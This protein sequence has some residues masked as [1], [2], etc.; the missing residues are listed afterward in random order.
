MAPSVSGWSCAT[1]VA[2]L[3]L[4][5][6]VRDARDIGDSRVCTNGRK[7]WAPN[8]EFGAA[9]RL[10]QKSRCPSLIPSPSNPEWSKNYRGVPSDG[11]MEVVPMD[12]NWH[13]D[14]CAPGQIAMNSFC[15]SLSRTRPFDFI[16][17]AF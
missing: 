12:E 2:G 17:P 15:R 10:E 7:E 9:P 5:C 16:S 13:L 3:I 1:T 8:S 6:C 4:K 14:K 11:H